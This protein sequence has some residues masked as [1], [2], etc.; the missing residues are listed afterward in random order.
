MRIQHRMVRRMHIA[1]I[2]SINTI[3]RKQ[4]WF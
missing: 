2:V 3:I 1:M 4:K